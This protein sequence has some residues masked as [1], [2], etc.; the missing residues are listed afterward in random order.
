MFN[1]I[2]YLT[3][4]SVVGYIAASYSTCSSVH[5]KFL[6]QILDH[7]ITHIIICVFFADYIHIFYT[8]IDY[9]YYYCTL[10][11]R[12]GPGR[13]LP[14]YIIYAHYSTRTRR[15]YTMTTTPSFAIG[16]Q[17]EYSI[18]YNIVDGNENKIVLLL[19]IIHIMLRHIFIFENGTCAHTAR[20]LCNYYNNLYNYH[21]IT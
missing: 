1:T 11:I 12:R 15:L 16:A 19:I 3:G 14:A 8:I 4:C 13:L 21:N 7:I 17:S 6:F 9:T 10:H 20:P 18:A 5:T 2:V